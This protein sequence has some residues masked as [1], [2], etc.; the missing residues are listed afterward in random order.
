MSRRQQWKL[1]PEDFVLGDT[2]GQ[3]RHDIPELV[4]FL[5]ILKSCIL[6]I[7]YNHKS[8]LLFFFLIDTYASLDNNVLN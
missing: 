3:K 2:L 5:Y 8:V 4:I 6:V 1:I 7:E